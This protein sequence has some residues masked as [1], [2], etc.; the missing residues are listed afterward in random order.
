MNKYTASIIVFLMA[1]CGKVVKQDAAL[2]DHIP[3]AQA[4]SLNNRAAALVGEVTSFNPDSTN[5]KLYMTALNLVDSAISKDSLYVLP[6]ESKAR[7]QRRIGALYASYSTLST[8]LRRNPDMD[9]QESVL[10]EQGLILEKLDSLHAARA[11]YHQALRIFKKKAES[12]PE[13]TK[14]RVNIAFLYLLLEGK[15]RALYEIQEIRL[16]FPENQEVTLMEGLI[17]EFN[18]EEF[19]G[20]F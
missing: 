9:D 7:I 15:E 11:K 4:V 16:E 3:D 6:Y 18:R 2:A 20:D 13:E 12:H 14:V 1:S 17:L 5:R 10:V 19:I 8:L